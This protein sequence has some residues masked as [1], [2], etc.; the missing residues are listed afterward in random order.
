MQKQFAAAT[1]VTDEERE[2]R[3]REVLRHVESWLDAG[4]GSCWLARDDVSAMMLNALLHFH[5]KRY[6]MGAACVM[7]NH[8]H[9]VFRPLDS[10]S[11]GDILH[12]WKSFS[13]NEVNRIVERMGTVWG[14][15]SFDTIVRDAQHLARVVQYVGKNPA[16][17]GI[18]REKWRRWVNP[19]WERIGW[20][21]RDEPQRGAA[22][23][24]CRQ[25][26]SPTSAVRQ[27]A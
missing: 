3:R 26:G 20:G 19:E 9:A 5:G 24:G 7:P 12:S 2:E 6:E 25:A 4:C 15:E 14:Q 23:D 1:F 16:K 13:S 21:F 10:H 18:P 11:L 27:D 22:G 8:A 17:A